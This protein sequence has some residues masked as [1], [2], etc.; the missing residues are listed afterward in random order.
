MFPRIDSIPDAVQKGIEKKTLSFALEYRNTQ[1]LERKTFLFE[2]S[3][4]ENDVNLAT[5][6]LIRK[7]AEAFIF[8]ND[9]TR[10]RLKVSKESINLIEKRFKAITEYQ[11]IISKSKT[12]DL[13]RAPALYAMCG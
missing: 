12:R 5:R 10:N 9:L 1:I 8:I 11:T 7:N 13:D 6:K 2:V 3:S 4:L